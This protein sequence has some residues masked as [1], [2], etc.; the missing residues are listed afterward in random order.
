VIL[1]GIARVPS[2]SFARVLSDVKDTVC[3]KL[4]PEKRMRNISNSFLI[5]NF[6]SV[7]KKEK[8][9][10]LLLMNYYETLVGC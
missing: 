5:V 3:A 4:I 10:G 7:Q 6:L 8:E 9:R 2:V 1:T